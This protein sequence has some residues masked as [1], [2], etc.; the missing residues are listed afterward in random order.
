MTT[1][2]FGRLATGETVEEIT[3]GRDGLS[4]AI[5]TF[6]AIL[7]RL[8][9]STAQGPRNVVLGFEEVAPYDGDGRYFGAIAGRCANRI[10]GGAFELD[11]TSYRLPL[12]QAG[13][14]H[15]HG[16]LRGFAQRLWQVE[17]RDDQSVTL[18]RRSPDGEEGYPGTLDVS[19]RYEIA[20]DRRLTI[21]LTATT[22]APTLVN[23]AGHAYFN[24]DGDGDILDHDLTVAAEAYTPIDADLIPTGE[25]R[26]VAGTPFDFRAARPIRRAE[27]GGRV[28]YDHNFVLTDA[29]SDTPRLA[30]RLSGQGGLTMDLFTTEPGLQVYDG[31]MI[32]PMAGT[33]GRSFSPNSGICL[34]PQVFPDAINNPRFP[35][36]VLRPGE[37]YRQVTAYRFGET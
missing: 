26:P 8:D 23:L 19:C 20:A 9:V 29:R 14:T 18:T 24:L 4:A 5:L 21:T 3:I 15:L 34:E 6:G 32:V 27:A 33:D 7:R 2:A 22:D 17:S 13:R 31:S 28:G 30:A 1:R 10:A 36:A 11:G 12:N 25:I 35:S 16:G 37:T